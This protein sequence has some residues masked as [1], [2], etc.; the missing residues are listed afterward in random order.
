MPLARTASGHAANARNAAG[1]SSA[2]VE[3]TWLQRLA[4][5]CV[6]AA[7]R[8]L[9]G[10]RIVLH[11]PSGADGGCVAA[12]RGGQ[13]SGTSSGIELHV[14]VDSQRFWPRVAFGGSVGA[15][16]SYIQGD[17]QCDD[18]VTLIRVLL[19]NQDAL[20]ALDRGW[21]RLSAPLRWLAHA[22]RRNTRRGSRRNIAAHYDLSNDFY[23]LFLDETMAYSCGIFEH[24]DSTLHHASLAKF[25]RV[26]RK[27]RLAPG[28][29][30][31]EIGS[32]WGG[33]AIY[34]AQHFGVRVTTT[35]I[36]RQQYELAA[37][38]IRAAGLE[39]RITLLAQDY[40]AVR[41]RFDKLVSIE[42]IEAVGHAYYPTF[43][44]AVQRLLKPDGLMLLQ[45]I[46]VAD[47]YYEHA[48]R[49]VDFIKRFVFP[50]SCIPSVVALL[51]VVARH[52]ALTPTQLEDITPHYVRTLQAWRERFHANLQQVR[53]LGFTESFIRL[54]DFYLAYCEAGFL[55][56]TIGD[57]QLLLAGP[58]WRDDPCGRVASQAVC[59]SG[60][61]LPE[62]AA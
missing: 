39:R 49:S 17:W 15:G 43:F 2:P 44:R 18:L 45:T 56:R 4:R 26:C 22:L 36:S 40:R 38:R 25:E 8:R 52:T 55:E 12:A 46:T 1:V 61:S 14:R 51:G 34:A 16:E 23:R 29:H 20:S 59:G 41:G 37:E 11:T 6:R 19:R 24:A 33:L 27:L 21:G 10:A 13:A 7:L 42:M 47:R 50:G 32:G 54:W 31:L 57:V 53:A 30:L 9:E 35:T 62:P 28:E 48:R 3:L 5:G 58:A 60:A